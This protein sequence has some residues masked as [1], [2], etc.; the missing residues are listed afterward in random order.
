M[1]F[2]FY[3]LAFML[4]M[5]TMGG[6]IALNY[7]AGDTETLFGSCILPNGSLGGDNMT[8]TCYYPNTSVFL[9][10]VQMEE[11]STGQFNYSFLVPN[12]TGTYSYS[13][14]CYF[15]NT[16][17]SSSDE[18]IV[19]DVSAADYIDIDVN[20][21]LGGNDGQ[22]GI[23]GW[24][25]FLSFIVALGITGFR[26]YNLMTGGE[27]L[28]RRKVPDGETPK[29][30]IVAATLLW[31]GYLVV[32]LICFVTFLSNPEVTIYFTLINLVNWGIGLNTI[33]WFID[34]IFYAV[35]RV[36]TPMGR[37]RPPAGF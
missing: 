1:K 14:T 19:L 17:A 30:N 3:V 8:L 31:A 11:F 15:N 12:L 24:F 10:A 23:Y 18:F 28:M 36:K 37:Y 20:T 32:W 7:V 34:W 22:S 9:S 6:V 27:A 35:Q 2:G 16:T 13:M 33:Y 25:F 5:I 26:T 4:L 21:N 29:Y